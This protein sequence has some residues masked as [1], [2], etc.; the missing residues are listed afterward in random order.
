MK[1]GRPVFITRMPLMAPSMSARASETRMATQMLRPYSVVRTPTTRPVKPVMAP[2]DRS[3]SPPIISKDTATA[4]IPMVDAPRS[5]VLAPA[6]VAKASVVTAKKTKIT[7]AATSAPLSGLFRTLVRA[8][9]LLTRSSTA[10]AVAMDRL[11]TVVVVR[12]AGAV[13][14]MV[15]RDREGWEA[16][17]GTPRGR[18]A[19]GR[20]A[21][22]ISGC[23]SRRTR[24][25]RR[26]CPW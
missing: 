10:V 2:A 22:T 7:T 14:A 16:P 13:V 25:P 15:L 21:A 9:E 18:A 20:R 23:R 19:P 4:M 6:A 12:W 3:N 11:L 26:R 17:R 24:R 8:D 1:L 5:Q